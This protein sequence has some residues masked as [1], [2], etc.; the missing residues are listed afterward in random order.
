[1]STQVGFIGLG[2]IGKWMALNIARH[3]PLTVYDI[4][5]EPLKELASAG[6]CVASSSREV[7]A[8]SDVL[9]TMVR[10]YAQT[11]EVFEGMDGALR[12]LRRGAVVVVMSTI[13]PHQ[14]RELGATVSAVGASL[15]D[16]PV[17]GGYLRAVEGTLTLMVGGPSEA[18]NACRPVLETMATNIFHI[19]PQ[20]GL[21]QA[22]KNINNMLLGI[23][24]VGASEA[25]VLG[26]KAGIDP[27]LLYEVITHS[28]GD[29]WAF[30][31]RMD[32]VITRDFET[33]GALEILVKDL[34]IALSMA[35]DLEM[36]LM[37]APIA[38]KA[39]QE[40]MAS[41]LGEEDDSAVVKAIEMNA[42]V[43][44]RPVDD[45]PPLSEKKT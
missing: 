28:T 41:G 30:R 25:M 4:R 10:T 14:A 40:A 8:A 20:V 35:D 24:E 27:R 18:L 21:G 23:Q 45:H 26:V 39:Y 33:R 38:L 7:A 12:D 44:V 17:S 15:L 11:R 22:A 16:S 13:S 36:R 1:M 19:G 31:N 2:A 6:A 43:E 37:L 5:Q 34:G 9:I 3:F 32:R 29:S 42:G